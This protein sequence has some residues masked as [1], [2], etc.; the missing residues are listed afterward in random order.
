M[1]PAGNSSK[2][3][4]MAV[5]HSMVQKDVLKELS[6]QTTDNGGGEC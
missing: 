5:K 3:V 6:R 2:E 1:D 4:V